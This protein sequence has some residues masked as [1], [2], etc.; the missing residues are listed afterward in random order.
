LDSF[1][2]ES[3]LVVVCHR[4]TDCDS[5]SGQPTFRDG[6]GST[7]AASRLRDEHASVAAVLAALEVPE[8][9]EA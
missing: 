4:A 9:L 8:K 5:I 1:R 6:F 3:L 7:S 2:H